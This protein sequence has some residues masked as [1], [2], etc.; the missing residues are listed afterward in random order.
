[1]GQ[2][3]SY[4]GCPGGVC[5][6]QQCANGR[7]YMRAMTDDDY[8]YFSEQS[9][10]SK[11]QVKEIFNTFLTANP[12]GLNRTEFSGLYYSL[13]PNES[14]E[15]VSNVATQLFDLFDVDKNGLIFILYDF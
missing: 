15:N 9:G 12:K 5:P 2:E 7:C 4:G 6:Y 14:K 11:D 1:M 8:Q 3:Q 10:L 13:R